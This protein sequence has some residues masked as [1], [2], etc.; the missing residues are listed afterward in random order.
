MTGSASKW[1]L[2]TQ[3]FTRALFSAR[4]RQSKRNY[5]HCR[6]PKMRRSSS[7][8]CTA[9]ILVALLL[10][11]SDGGHCARLDADALRRLQRDDSVSHQP[12]RQPQQQ[13]R[14]DHPCGGSKLVASDVIDDTILF[15]RNFTA[16]ATTTTVT[17]VLLVVSYR[18]DLGWR[19]CAKRQRT[20][21]RCRIYDDDVKPTA[22]PRWGC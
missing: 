15:D 3:R 12:R 4:R 11:R 14:V 19:P 6:K 22:D 13:V 2:R 8:S 9:L 20:R 21:W 17:V 7:W 16:A 1:L 18:S 5:F 10:T